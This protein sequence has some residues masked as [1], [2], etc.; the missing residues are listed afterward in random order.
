M[1]IDATDAE[2]PRPGEPLSVLESERA[3][4]QSPCVS[5]TRPLGPTDLE[6]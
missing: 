2:P 5:R 6:R 1:T 3:M 4:G